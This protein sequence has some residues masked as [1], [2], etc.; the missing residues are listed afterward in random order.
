MPSSLPRQA[1]DAALAKA[2]HRGFSVALGLLPAWWL[3]P[4]RECPKHERPKGPRLKPPSFLTQPWESHCFF[5]HLL[6]VTLGQPGFG[7]G[8]GHSQG[9]ECWEA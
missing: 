6:L 2:V 1:A 5:H 9:H 7:V 4:K 3:S 8:G